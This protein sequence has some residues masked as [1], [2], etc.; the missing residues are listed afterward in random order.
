M[1]IGAS[2]GGGPGS[3]GGGIKTTTFGILILYAFGVLKRKEYVEVFKR[4]IDWELINKAL[5]IVVIS[6]FYISC[7]LQQLYYQ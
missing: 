5:A 7:C 3:T 4:R 1:F 6:I 2:G